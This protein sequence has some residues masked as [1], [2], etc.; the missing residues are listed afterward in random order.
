MEHIVQNGIDREDRLRLFYYSMFMNGEKGMK[1]AY[2]IDSTMSMFD[3]VVI[4]YRRV[5]YDRQA[6]D[7][8]NTMTDPTHDQ[9]LKPGTIQAVP[10]IESMVESVKSGTPGT[11]EPKVPDPKRYIDT[12]DGKEVV[13]QGEGTTVESKHNTAKPGEGGSNNLPEKGPE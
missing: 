6:V 3:P 12:K 13:D 9:V 10:A 4:N 7:K 5:K 11:P 2:I 1:N 8:S